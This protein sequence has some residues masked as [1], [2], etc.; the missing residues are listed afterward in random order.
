MVTDENIVGEAVFAYSPYN[1]IYADLDTAADF[2]SID[3][4]TLYA[5]FYIDDPRNVSATGEAM[6]TA[7]IDWTQYALANTTQNTYNMEA[8]QIEATVSMAKTML[9]FVVLISAAGI[10]LYENSLSIYA[11]NLRSLKTIYQELC[12]LGYD[13]EPYRLFNVTEDQINYGTISAQSITGAA[14]IMSWITTITTVAIVFLLI[15]LWMRNDYKDIAILISIGKSRG[16][17]AF[18]YLLLCTVMICLA[19]RCAG[20]VCAAVLHFYG[21]NLLQ[22]VMNLMRETSTVETDALIQRAMTGTM[23][24]SNYAAAELKLLGLAEAAMLLGMGKIFSCKPT[25]LFHTS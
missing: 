24:F 16:R 18:D 11:G 6:K 2:F 4:E 14:Q 8:A 9:L 19:L 1:R 10:E 17:I 7:A 3:P 25:I 21:N 23:R 15:V 13:S 12:D 22:Y 5:T 20:P